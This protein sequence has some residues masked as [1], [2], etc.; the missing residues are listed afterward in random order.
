ML[1]A[2]W[3]LS[4]IG[5]K[6]LLIISYENVS[7][8]WALDCLFGHGFNEKRRFLI[9]THAVRKIFRPLCFINSWN[10]TNLIVLLYFLLY[11]ESKDPFWLN[12]QFLTHSPIVN[13][14][15]ICF[16][17]DLFLIKLWISWTYFI[18]CLNYDSVR[19]ALTCFYLWDS[20]PKYMGFYSQLLIIEESQ[21]FCFYLVT[22]LSTSI[23]CKQEN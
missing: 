7:V 8:F 20:K 23:L 13:Y 4:G 5:L 12:Y 17:M 2:W 1:P 21:Y 6:I 15:R 19:Y 22:I 9:S 14:A 18:F 11:Y 10:K 3:E 16:V